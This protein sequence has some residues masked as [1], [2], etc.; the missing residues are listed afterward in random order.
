[1]SKDRSSDELGYN[2]KFDLVSKFQPTVCPTYIKMMYAIVLSILYKQEI[3]GSTESYITNLVGDRMELQN[4]VGLNSKPMSLIGQHHNTQ[5]IYL[6]NS[7]LVMDSQN[8]EKH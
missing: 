2:S 3:E 1:M 7:L 6:S 8:L 4:Q 5:I